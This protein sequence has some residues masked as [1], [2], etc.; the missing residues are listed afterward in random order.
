M[1]KEDPTNDYY[2]NFAGE[3]WNCTSKDNE[4]LVRQW[5][6]IENKDIHGVIKEKE[7]SYLRI[8]LNERDS[9]LWLHIIDDGEQWF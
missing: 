3:V 8:E 1:I 4:F 2:L 7:I 9:E 6:T 5:G